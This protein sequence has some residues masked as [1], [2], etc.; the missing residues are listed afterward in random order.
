VTAARSSRSQAYRDAMAR[1][2]AAVHV[3]TTDGEGGRA[4]VT[5]SAVASVTDD[6]PTLLVCLNRRSRINPIFKQNCVLAVNTLRAGQEDLSAM[7]AGRGGVAMQDRF[8]EGRWTRLATG[9]PILTDALVSFDGRI[10]AVQ[11]VG[12]HSVFFVEVIE[13]A[14]GEPGSALVYYHRAYSAVAHE[15]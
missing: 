9:S 13:T 3:I 1:L 2:S 7:F 8:D 5:A 12:T 15:R 14:I 11:E 4:G 6:P 10:T